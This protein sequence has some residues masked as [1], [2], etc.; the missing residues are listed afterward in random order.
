[1]GSRPFL[2]DEAQP[3]VQAE[4]DDQ[5]RPRRAA[6]CKQVKNNI[7]RVLGAAEKASVG[8]CPG[9]QI[10]VVRVLT[11]ARAQPGVLCVNFDGRLPELN[12]Y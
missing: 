9:T 12:P 11:D 4:E 3:P 5:Q 1:M 7:V 2:T 10:T 8:L 6:F